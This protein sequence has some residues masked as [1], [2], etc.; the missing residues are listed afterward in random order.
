MSFS[1]FLG[2][3][4]SLIGIAG[5]V[6][7]I[8]E[9]VRRG[10]GKRELLIRAA[11]IA[12]VLVAT[13]SLGVFISRATTITIRPPSNPFAG[14]SDRTTQ[15]PAFVPGTTP[16]ATPTATPTSTATP[17][18]SPTATVTSEVI[19]LKR[20][21]TCTCDDPIQ[22]TINRMVINTTT[23]TMTWNLTLL[24]TSAAPQA[25]HFSQFSLQDASGTLYQGSGVIL[26]AYDNPKSPLG[27]G[28]T[29]QGTV[30]FSFV[31]YAGGAYVLAAGI[32]PHSGTSPVIQFDP[33]SFTF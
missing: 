15:I 11:I 6:M 14:A 31:P 29:V 17:M 25:F 7:A 9:Y 10:P 1:G 21:L 24:N 28:A 4:V 12:I 16:T 23:R 22:V 18:L 26:S 27:A 32:E 3:I 30:I 5:A 33:A 20:V 19:K 8:L 13:L 2:M